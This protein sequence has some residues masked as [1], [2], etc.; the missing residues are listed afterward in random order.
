MLTSWTRRSK[1]VLESNPEYRGFTWDFA[2]SEPARGTTQLVKDMRGKKMPQVGRVEITIIEEAQSRW[3]AFQQ[4][5]LDYLALPD[6][7]APTALDGDRLKPALADEGIRLFRAPDPDMTYTAF[8]VRD[9]VIG[10][11]TKEK[12]ALRRAMAMAYDIDDEIKVVRKGQAVALQ[13]PIPFGR[14]RPRSEL[15]QRQPVR[16]GDREQAARLLRLQEGQGRLAHAARRQA[17]R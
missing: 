6:T 8:N 4:K 11:F 5:Q 7:F 16:P 1:I 15:P 12:I 2:P 10:G 14:R 3:L 9:P 17:A 13:M